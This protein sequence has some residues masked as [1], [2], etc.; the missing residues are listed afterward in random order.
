MMRATPDPKGPR[1]E[2]VGDDVD[3]LCALGLW[4]DD[5]FRHYRR[6]HWRHNDDLRR[7]GAEHL[8]LQS[9]REL[10]GRECDEHQQDGVRLGPHISRPGCG[11]GV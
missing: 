1:H 11:V 6:R 4:A 5:D 9:H 10:P 8:S 3:L 2:D 7:R